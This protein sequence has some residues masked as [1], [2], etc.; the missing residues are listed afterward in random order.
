MGG[1]LPANFSRGGPRQGSRVEHEDGIEGK[2]GLRDNL[3]MTVLR[4]VLDLL[5]SCILTPLYKEQQLFSSTSIGKTANSCT[6]ALANTWLLF[7]HLFNFDWRVI[8]ATQHNNVFGPPGKKELS[9]VEKSLISCVEPPILENCTCL[10]GE[11]KITFHQGWAGH[12]DAANTTT[13]QNLTCWISNRDFEARQR[14]T[15]G[16]ELDSS[17]IFNRF[18]PIAQRTP[19]KSPGGEGPLQISKG[20]GQSGL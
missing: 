6:T 20:D 7:G 18:T 1:R 13:P 12:P 19:K 16:Y 9:I 2:A 10:I 11:P 8:P 15:D 14:R 3:A 17:H 4:Y 5:R